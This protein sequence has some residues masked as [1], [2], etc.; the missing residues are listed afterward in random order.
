MPPALSTHTYEFTDGVNT[1]SGSSVTF[2]G[3]SLA[4]DD[5][6]TV[7][8]PFFAFVGFAI[9]NSF[10]LQHKMFNNK[11]TDKKKTDNSRRTFF[12]VF[13]F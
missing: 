4:V 3:W 10:Q 5:D 6:F 1:R 11:K 12:F 2:G 13:R 7:I 9:K 8:E